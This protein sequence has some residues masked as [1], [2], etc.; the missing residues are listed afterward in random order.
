ML[1]DCVDNPQCT[2][3]HSLQSAAFTTAD[4]LLVQTMTHRQVLRSQGMHAA[5][6]PHPHG[7]FM[8]WSPSGPP[9]DKV[10]NVGLLVTDP[11]SN[12]P[13]NATL[14][15]L[16]EV[17]CEHGASL[18]L[19]LAEAK[20]GSAPLRVLSPHKG[21]WKGQGKCTPRL[22]AAGAPLPAKR[23]AAGAGAGAGA[24]G[25]GPGGE[26][27]TLQV[28]EPPADEEQLAKRLRELGKP[29]EGDANVQGQRTL[30]QVLALARSRSR[31]RARARARA[32]AFAPN[33]NPKPTLTLPVGE[34]H[35]HLR[36]R[37]H[38]R[39]PRVARAVSQVQG[40]G[41]RAVRR[42]QPRADGALVVVLARHTRAR[43]L[44][45]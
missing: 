22:S 21:G 1:L 5:V 43:P 7:N 27:A 29:L 2:Q 3:A 25:A 31:A 23:C 12:M 9:R 28:L 40:P 38:R 15:Q 36:T 17:C 13:D 4:A 44:D 20:D 42:Q 8:G 6:W 24:P 30:Y 11:E 16:A 10:S 34:R 45:E 33:P 37:H 39:W 18:F 14:Q 26:G 35:G 32:L 41:R 19:V